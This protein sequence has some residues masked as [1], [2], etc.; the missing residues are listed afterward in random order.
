MFTSHLVPLRQ[1]TKM[2]QL[3][4]PFH[5]MP[6]HICRGDYSVKTMF[7]LEAVITQ[8]AFVPVSV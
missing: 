2:P 5:T 7:M 8:R 6:T 1:A 4:P 3:A